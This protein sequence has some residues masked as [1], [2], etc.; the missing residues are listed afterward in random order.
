MNLFQLLPWPRSLETS[1]VEKLFRRHEN[2]P[3]HHD[4]EYSLFSGIF[5]KACIYP[6]YTANWTLIFFNLF[7]SIKH[8]YCWW[9]LDDST[10]VFQIIWLLPATHLAMSYLCRPGPYSQT[11][12]IHF[13]NSLT[14]S[15]CTAQMAVETELGQNWHTCSQHHDE[16]LVWRSLAIVKA[17]LT[18]TQVKFA[19]KTSIKVF[20][21]FWLMLHRAPLENNSFT[22]IWENLFEHIHIFIQIFLFLCYIFYWTCAVRCIL[23]LAS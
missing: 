13:N 1:P 15:S 16:A 6:I 5:D 20:I 12:S 7:F 10:V 18:G 23:L 11:Y 22:T 2:N 3:A 8:G 9:A 21:G 14:W 17:I 4:I 19:Y